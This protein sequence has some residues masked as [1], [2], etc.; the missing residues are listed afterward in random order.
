[1]AL[2]SRVES[3]QGPTILYCKRL[4]INMLINVLQYVL[5]TLKNPKNLSLPY[6]RY[7]RK[8][9]FY[10]HT[11]T[12]LHFAYISTVSKAHHQLSFWSILDAGRPTKNYN[13]L[14]SPALKSWFKRG[15]S[16]VY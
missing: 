5:K 6:Y 15:V 4:L 14:K 7:N 13:S 1:M 8:S 16:I 9:T 3:Y 11:V 10:K 12:Q 2:C